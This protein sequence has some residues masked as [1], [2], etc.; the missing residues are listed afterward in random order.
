MAFLKEWLIH[1]KLDPERH[2]TEVLHVI[3]NEVPLIQN[4]QL[5]LWVF[6]FALFSSL[7]ASLNATVLEN[8]VIS[9]KPS[10][11]TVLI[12]SF[13][14]QVQLCRKAYELLEKMKPRE[15]LIDFIKQLINQKSDLLAQL[16]TIS[17]LSYL[18]VLNDLICFALSVKELHFDEQQISTLLP[19]N[20]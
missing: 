7:L 17:S 10:E 11:L 14:E 9:I 1:N 13:L 5:N 18:V 12:N 2:F 16:R 8:Y 3:L 15:P 6:Q 20:Y 19:R 4:N